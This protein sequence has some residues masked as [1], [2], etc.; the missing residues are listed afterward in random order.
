[1]AAGQA[2]QDG[3]NRS[4][5]ETQASAGQDQRIWSQEYSLQNWAQLNLLWY[6]GPG[7]VLF[8]QLLEWFNFLPVPMKEEV[9]SLLNR[10]VLRI[11][12]QSSI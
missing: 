4:H 2:G 8:L 1:M 11:P 12:Q 6:S 7:E 9:L 3:P 5:Q 10:L